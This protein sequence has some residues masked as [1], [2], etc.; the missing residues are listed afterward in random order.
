MAGLE[1]LFE[2]P[3]GLRQAVVGAFASA[4]RQRVRENPDLGLI[5]DEDGGDAGT[6]RTIFPVLTAGCETLP[7]AE[8]IRRR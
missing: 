6:Q 5:D 2:F 7:A 4:V 3:P 1:R 8:A